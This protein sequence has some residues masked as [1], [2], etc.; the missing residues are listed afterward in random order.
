[1][2][3]SHSSSSSSLNT[4]RQNFNPE[5]E[6]FSYSSQHAAFN[7][8]PLECSPHFLNPT[9]EVIYMPLNP[10]NIPLSLQPTC[11]SNEKPSDCAQSYSQPIC[12]G[13]IFPNS[14]T[15]PDDA[16]GDLTNIP[17]A[18]IPPENSSYD[19]PDHLLSESLGD[20]DHNAQ[21]Q[22]QLLLLQKLIEL[23]L[24]EYYNSLKVP[25]ALQS[26]SNFHPQ[27][28]ESLPC[29][30]ES[31]EL[32]DHFGQN[33]AVN[34]EHSDMSTFLVPVEAKFEG[35]SALSLHITPRDDNNSSG[36][37][38][39]VTMECPSQPLVLYPFT[40]QHDTSPEDTSSANQSIL[41]TCTT[42]PAA[43][44][45][46]MKDI[47]QC[48]QKGSFEFSSDSGKD[49]VESIRGHTR[50]GFVLLSVRHEKIKEGKKASADSKPGFKKIRSS[51]N[52]GHP[53]PGAK[54]SNDSASKKSS[55]KRLKYAKSEAE[56]KRRSFK[57]SPKPTVKKLRNDGVTQ[58]SVELTEDD[59]KGLSPQS[60]FRVT[61][62]ADKKQAWVAR[63]K[64]GCFVVHDLWTTKLPE[65]VSKCAEHL[66][67]SG[68]DFFM[69]GDKYYHLPYPLND[70]INGK[71]VACQKPYRV[72]L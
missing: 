53:S 13:F 32:D 42:A 66:K 9:N 3:S 18:Q 30:I 50:P 63:L 55:R 26:E 10:T 58:C 40:V 43:Q 21:R 46:T 56:L 23:Q 54:A 67:Q 49:I 22:L 28:P 57:I 14:V 71:C 68:S 12:H 62:F 11:V 44:T 19:M 20:T 34:N 8:Y 52:L 61:R 16:T 24:T 41:D 45:L 2:T 48:V 17:S 65:Y 33:W 64:E 39:P 37:G 15:G 35:E 69:H 1:M 29:I 47:H 7:A 38:S 51:P 25:F 31:Q 70:I 59:I 36:Q 6:Q 60:R 4:L 5:G 72:L 27:N